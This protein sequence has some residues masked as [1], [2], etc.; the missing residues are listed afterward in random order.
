MC[1]RR[2]P[3]YHGCDFARC[4][5]EVSEKEIFVVMMSC[6]CSVNMSIDCYESG[7]GRLRTLTVMSF[8]H[9]SWMYLL[10]LVDSFPG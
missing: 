3:P 4:K 1:P 9:P 8:L 2:G 7:S 6:R 10:L 5:S